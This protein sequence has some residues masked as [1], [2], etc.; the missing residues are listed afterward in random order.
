MENLSEKTAK[1]YLGLK[2][3]AGVMIPTTAGP[4]FSRRSRASQ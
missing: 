3:R 4:F 2:G 1:L